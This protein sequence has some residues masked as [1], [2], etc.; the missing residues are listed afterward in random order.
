M[1]NEVMYILWCENSFH[2]Y[3]WMYHLLNS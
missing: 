3:C 2:E 1:V